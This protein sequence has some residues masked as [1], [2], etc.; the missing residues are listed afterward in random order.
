MQG[1]FHGLVANRYWYTLTGEEG[2]SGL[3]MATV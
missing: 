1:Q 3:L 2:V